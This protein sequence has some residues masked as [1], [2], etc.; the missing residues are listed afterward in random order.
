M[1]GKM[2]VP[3]RLKLSDLLG[4][5]NLEGNSARFLMYHEMRNILSL[6]KEEGE[7]IGL[8]V[9]PIPGGGYNTYISH[10]EK[11][12]MK[13]IEVNDI[14][15]EVVGN[16]LRPLEENDKLKQGMAELFFW[17]KPEIDKMRQRE[18]DA[19]KNRK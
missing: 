12:P 17:F 4:D 6:S 15:V 11:D 1:K 5:S 8:V 16:I 13:E 2:S 14:I 10:P 9:E 18:I 19:K 7:Q 3:V